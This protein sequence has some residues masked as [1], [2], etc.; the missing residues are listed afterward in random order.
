MRPVLYLSAPI[1]AGYGESLEDAKSDV[2]RLR[3][4]LVS[5]IVACQEAVEMGW[6]PISPHAL[7]LAVHDLDTCYVD[8]LKQLNRATWLHIDFSLIR[9]CDAVWRFGDKSPGAD[10]EVAFAKTIG[11][12][13]ALQTMP[14]SISE[15]LPGWEP[16]V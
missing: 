10:A 13:V 12:P 6:A 2:A 15:L 3:D 1:T 4:N 5:G 14:P 8:E 7:S 11:K 9:V 16:K